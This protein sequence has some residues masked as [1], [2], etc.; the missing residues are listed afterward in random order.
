MAAR[1]VYVFL[2][3][4]FVQGSGRYLRPSHV[5]LFTEEQA[6]KCTDDERL[7]WVRSAVEPGFRPAGER[8]YADTSREPIRD[9]LMRNQWLQLGIMDKH[10]PPGHSITSST[11]VNYLVADFVELF[12][13]DLTKKTSWQ[14]QMPGVGPTLTKPR[15]SRWH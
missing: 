14:K 10:T 1:A 15:F 12:A 8:W 13:P 6:G 4:G 3:G 11:P 2:Y 9:D 5:Y 7:A